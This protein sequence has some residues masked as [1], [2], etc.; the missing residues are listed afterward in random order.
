[1]GIIKKEKTKKEPA[2]GRFFNKKARKNY[3]L[4][5]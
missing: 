3:F 2:F 1:M 4:F 5:K